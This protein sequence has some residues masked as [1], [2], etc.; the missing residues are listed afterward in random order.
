M[1]KAKVNVRWAEP[2]LE[3]DRRE[4]AE[5]YRQYLATDD[6]FEGLGPADIQKLIDLA[7]T[8]QQL[9]KEHR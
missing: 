6:D 3:R 9:K 4:L 7:K 5:F 1:R 8:L 2:D